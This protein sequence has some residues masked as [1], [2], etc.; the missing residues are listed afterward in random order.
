MCIFVA[1]GT[2]LSIHFDTTYMYIID[3]L[4]VS[5]FVNEITLF[6]LSVYSVSIYQRYIHAYIGPW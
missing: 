1:V 4:N 3:I 2:R 5:L 6:F